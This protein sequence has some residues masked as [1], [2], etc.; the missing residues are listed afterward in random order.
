MH[1]ITIYVSIGQSN[2]SE[3]ASQQTF[4]DDYVDKHF[5]GVVPQ[6]QPED[7]FAFIDLHYLLLCFV[8]FTLTGGGLF[9]WSDDFRK[10]LSQR[11]LTTLISYTIILMY[12]EGEAASQQLNFKSFLGLKFNSS[13]M[14]PAQYK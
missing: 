3:A 8:P 2:L 4:T 10:F 9:I 12:W 1:C 13:Q 7:F 6:L 11:V 5:L 14:P